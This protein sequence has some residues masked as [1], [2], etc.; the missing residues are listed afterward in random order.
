MRMRPVVLRDAAAVLELVVAR[1]IADLGAPDYTSADLESDWGSSA[2]RLNN[3]TRVI[4]D[5]EAIVGY[6]IMRPDEALVIVH[7]DAVGQGIGSELLAWSETREL[8]M[9]RA[10]HRRSAAAADPAGGRLLTG[11]GYT[12]VRSYWR[13]RL[14][15]DG[16]VPVTA[17]PAG[18]TLRELDLDGDAIAIH[19]L[20]QRS[21]AAV[22]DYAPHTFEAFREEHL[23]AHD[24]DSGLSLVAAADGVDAP[25]GFL[26][27]HRWTAEQTG[28]V[29]L[30]GVDPDHRSWGLGRALLAR[31]F[32]GFAAAGLGIA[33]LGVASDNP[34]ALALYEDVGMTARFQIDSYERDAG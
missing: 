3:D 4:Q 26:I 29:G 20:D 24:V 1:D 7:P 2:V 6:A 19:E 16:P 27:A 12:K 21:F 32:A 30:L 15:L 22:A 5:G 34:R 31:A 13:M 25:A 11:A 17:L 33:E 10:A 23:A 14:V 18:I 9:G 8:E 28:Y